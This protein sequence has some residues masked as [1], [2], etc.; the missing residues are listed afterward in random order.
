[1]EEKRGGVEAAEEAKPF[2]LLFSPGVL[3]HLDS[4]HPYPP[5]RR[6]GS[7]ASLLHSFLPSQYPQYLR[8]LLSV[9]ILS[10]QH[11]QGATL[12]IAQHF[13]ISTHCTTNLESSD[14]PAA[15]HS[16]S[17]RMVQSLDSTRPIMAPSVS[18]DSVVASL[19]H[20]SSKAV[21]CDCRASHAPFYI[22]PPGP[23]AGLLF[24][25]Y[26]SHVSLS[27]SLPR[28]L[29]LALSGICNP[30]RMSSPLTILR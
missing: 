21:E 26:V 16:N 2:L 11:R 15:I 18:V 30:R 3:L 7:I 5:S 1:M 17:S 6:I 19:S 23:G 22:S 27:P 14:Q 12:R 29:C 10:S 4:S 8:H 28:T 25:S 20:L 24:L 13:H 9:E